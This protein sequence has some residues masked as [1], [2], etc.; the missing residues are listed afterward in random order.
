MRYD[1]Y[2]CM[3]RTLTHRTMT[4]RLRYI[5]RQ[6]VAVSRP[7]SYCSS[8]AQ[9][10]ISGI[11]RVKLPSRLRWRMVTRSSRSFCRSIRITRERYDIYECRFMWFS[12]LH[13]FHL[14]IC[15]LAR[16][17]MQK[18]KWFIGMTDVP[19]GRQISYSPR[20]AANSRMCD[21]DE[22]WGSDVPALASGQKAR[23]SRAGP[24]QVQAPSAEQALKRKRG[25][26]GD[27]MPR[28][29]LH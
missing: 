24:R 19:V 23:P 12:I 6:N 15:Q 9:A 1:S 2:W 21:F 14:E 7:P 27:S 13:C 29:T 25:R 5:S 4:T 16:Q 20:I 28:R 26:V 10:S 17:R 22:V 3:A 8:M 11:T 18:A